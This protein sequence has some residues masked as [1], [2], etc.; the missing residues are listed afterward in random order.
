MILRYWRE[1]AVN[2]EE[3][4]KGFLQKKNTKGRGL[5]RKSSCNEVS[6]SSEITKSEFF[7]LF[8]QVSQTEQVYKRSNTFK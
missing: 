2:R 1:I 5:L 4:Q 6:L 7:D 8:E 3:K